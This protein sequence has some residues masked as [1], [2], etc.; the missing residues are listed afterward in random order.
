MLAWLPK[1]RQ[2]T[3]MLKVFHRRAPKIDA[4]FENNLCDCLLKEINRCRA[5]LSMR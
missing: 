3:N 4:E 1:Y 5:Q 2:D